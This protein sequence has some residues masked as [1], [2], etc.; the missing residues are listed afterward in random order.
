MFIIDEL[1]KRKNTVKYWRKR[2]VVIGN[3]TKIYSSVT[4]GSEPYMVIIGNNCN[5]TNNAE[6]M[7][8]DGGVHVLRNLYPD[9]KDIDNFRGK[10]IIGDNVFIG[11]HA[12]IMQ[13]IKIGSNCIIG[14]GSVVTKDV[15]NNSVVA[16]VPAKVICSVEDYMRKNQPFFT[17]TK[18][19]SAN[20]KKEFLMRKYC[21]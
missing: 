18:K 10:T 17:H 20:Q 6:F 5:I 19:M 16:G 4:F 13:G 15:P 9:L 11:N 3:N 1:K 14:Y 7:T 21:K 12:C 2:G 8:H